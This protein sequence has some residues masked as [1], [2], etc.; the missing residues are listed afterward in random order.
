MLAGLLL[1]G[2]GGAPEPPPPWMRSA[3]KPRDENFRGGPAAMLMAYDANHDGILTREELIA[4]LKAEFAA[5][6]T[7]HKG[8]LDPDQVAAINQKRID[9]DQATATPA[10]GLEPGWLYRL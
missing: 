7:D 6:D 9:A 4:G 1:A 5:Y 8:C 10:A 2:C 3:E